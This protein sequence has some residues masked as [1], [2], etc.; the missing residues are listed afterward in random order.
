[1]HTNK[2]FGT[3]G[4]FGQI[5]NGNRRGVRC[6]NA[7]FRD[8]FFNIFDNLVFQGKILKDRLD[9]KLYFPNPE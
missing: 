9:Y 1:M 3:F 7:I 5:S 8:N 2:V 4:S 6:E